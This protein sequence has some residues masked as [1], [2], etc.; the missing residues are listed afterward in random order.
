LPL[1]RGLFS[2]P[3]TPRLRIAAQLVAARPFSLLKS[4][5]MMMM[6]CVMCCCLRTAVPPLLCPPCPTTKKLSTKSAENYLLIPVLV[7]KHTLY[8]LLLSPLAFQHASTLHICS[9]FI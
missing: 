3:S 9:C 6:T 2:K 1:I 4:K 5:M 7:A 8:L